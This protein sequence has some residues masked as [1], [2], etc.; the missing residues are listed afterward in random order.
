MASCPATSTGWRPDSTATVVPTFRRDVRDSARALP[1]NGPALQASALEGPARAP[2]PR[3]SSPQ[4]NQAHPFSQPVLP[5]AI[6][7]GCPSSSSRPP[8]QGRPHGRRFAVLRGGFASLDPHR[9]HGFGAYEED[10]SRA[11]HSDLPP[12]PLD[13]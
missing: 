9:S 3:L 5:E 12:D 1:M 2:A 7:L 8:P 13:H 10:G 4:I 6:F 11:G